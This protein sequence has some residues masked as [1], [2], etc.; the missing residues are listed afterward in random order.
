VTQARDQNNKHDRLRQAQ[1]ANLK[2]SIAYVLCLEK[3]H[4]T[5]AMLAWRVL[6]LGAG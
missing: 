3:L 1:P 6:L 4:K 2:G 5:C